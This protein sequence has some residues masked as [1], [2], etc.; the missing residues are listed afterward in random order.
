MERILQ[1]QYGLQVNRDT[2]QTYAE[3]F[4]NEVADRHGVTVADTTVWVDFLSVLFGVSIIEELKTEFADKLDRKGIDSLVGDPDET[5]PA[6]KGVK[7]DL[8]EDNMRRKQEG[9]Q[10]RRWPEGFT[11]GSLYL[12]QISCLAELQCGNT[13]FA[14]A[15][16]LALVFPLRGVDYW[17]T[18]DHDAYNDVLPNRVKCLIH[19]LR[20][21]ARGDERVS[22]LHEAGELEEFQ[23]YLED[24][25]ETAYE[26]LVAT[27]NQDHLEFW[28]E[29]VEGRCL[30]KSEQ[31]E[32][33]V[34]NATQRPAR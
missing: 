20:I 30:V 32:E 34:I 2:V 28:D 31:A 33:L 6:K 13:A 7:Q 25:Y 8:Y 24:K 26:E 16:A 18:D 21:R 5:Y 17:L 12:P 11:V 1:N 15:P 27:L 4:G 22:E 23:E 3:R 19:R 9:K 29:G 14:R 10:P